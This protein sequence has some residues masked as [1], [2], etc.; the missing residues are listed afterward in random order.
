MVSN[1]SALTAVLRREQDRK[2]ANASSSS[3]TSSKRG[4]AAK[5][6]A[7]PTT[8]NPNKR[9]HLADIMLKVSMSIK[10][11]G[12]NEHTVEFQTTTVNTKS[13]HEEQ[14]MN[15]QQN[16]QGEHPESKNMFW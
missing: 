7:S 1:L 8:D 3:S 10:K 9:H 11:K 16:S 13:S 15:D 2:A 14:T 6:P 5:R 4:V 12:Y